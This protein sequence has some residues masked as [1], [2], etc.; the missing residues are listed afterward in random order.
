M[1]D[2]MTSLHLASK[3]GHLAI[4]ALLLERDADVSAKNVVSIDLW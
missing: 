4:V 1:Q 3:N 2:D